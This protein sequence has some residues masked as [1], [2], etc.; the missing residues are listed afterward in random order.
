MKTNTVEGIKPWWVYRW[1]K[2]Y[3]KPQFVCLA[4][5]TLAKYFWKEY[6]VTESQLFRAVGV[7]GFKGEHIW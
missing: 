2:C 4:G 6:G 5:R 7:N 3:K 1:E